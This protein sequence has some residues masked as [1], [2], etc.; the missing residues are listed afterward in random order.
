MSIGHS[1]KIVTDGLVFYYDMENTK[2]SWKGEPT[3]NIVPSPE[4]NSRFT[5]SNSWATY[6]VNQYNNNTFFSIGTV[7]SVTDNI[8]TLS[9]VGREIRTFDAIH[10]QTA[11]GGLSST[12]Y[13]IKKINST[14]FSVHAYNSNQSG[15]Q[16]YI[17]PATGWHKCHESIAL[18][19]RIAINATN[20]PTMWKGSPHL[21][22]SALVKEVVEGAGP[23]GQ[24]V[25]RLHVN[26]TDGIADG[27]AYGVTPSVTQGDVITVSYW[28]RSS[29]ANK[30]HSFSTYFGG[31]ITGG[32]GLTPTDTKWHKVTSTWVA[33]VTYDYTTYF[34]PNATTEVPYYIDI[35]DFQVEVNREN[36]PTPF[37]IAPRGTSEALV[38][39][40]GNHSITVNNVKYGDGTFSFD[41]SGAGYLSLPSDLGYD[42]QVSVFAWFKRLGTP[43][44]GYHIICSPTR[45]EISIPESTG[46]IRTGVVTDIR[47][48][49]NHGSGLTDGNWHYIG[50]VFDGVTKTSYIDGVNVGTQSVSTGTLSN[51]PADRRVG[52]MTSYA[53]N[54]LIDSFKVY[55]KALTEAEVK[56]NF[57]AHRNRYGI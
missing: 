13:F 31:S 27:M 44:G 6:N 38:D 21:P 22:N 43:I 15:S 25:M 51:Q 23:D 42:T 18:D 24:S 28:T 14:Q 7:G 36:A 47:Y 46:A 53:S 56:Q 26:R 3:T 29:M 9:S 49:S 10:P 57:N 16:G 1:P 19:Q 40:T 52:K 5:T 54:G 37:T 17:D 4:H 55:D 32:G 33:S 48:V 35:C 2:K 34:W 11:G 50:F 41:S 45:L 20:F 30:G 8:V 39:L 12:H